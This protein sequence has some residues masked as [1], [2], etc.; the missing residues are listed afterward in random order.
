MLNRQEFLHGLLMTGLG[1]LA[2][3]GTDGSPDPQPDAMGSGS[4]NNSVDAGPPDAF[5]GTCGTTAVVI[6]SNHGHTMTVSAADLESTTAVTYDIRGSSNHAHTVRI[7]PAEFAMLKAE[8][9][10]LVTS[11]EN[12]GHPHTV[13]VRCTA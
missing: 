9:T 1:A 3:C 2:A 5:T 8:G 4:N 10:I 7:T 13:R 6:G 11:S 12:S